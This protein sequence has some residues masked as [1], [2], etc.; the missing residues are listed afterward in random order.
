MCCLDKP[1]NNIYLNFYD[2]SVLFDQ[3]EEIKK[4][5]LES[6]DKKLFLIPTEENKF[7]I[8]T[9]TGD[10]EI[11]DPDFISISQI[12]KMRYFNHFFK[13]FLSSIYLESY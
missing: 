8:K 3:M 4:S 12:N 10:I 6:K 7:I 13:D 11:K 9:Y 5:V 2:K 1:A